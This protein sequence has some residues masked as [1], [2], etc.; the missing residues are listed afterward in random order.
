M[1]AEFK[2]GEKNVGDEYP[3]FIIAEATQN[4]NGD[5]NLAK[6]LIVSAKEI[7]CDCI[8]FQTFTTEEFCADKK[9]IFT[10]Y[11]QGKEVS[12]SE[13]EM[14][15]RYEFT[16]EEWKEI[17]EFCNKTGILFLTTVQDPVNLELM[18]GLGLQGIK[19]GSDDF[20]HLVNLKLFAK[21]G[22]PLIIS[23]GM[24]DLED[25]KRTIGA[26]L[27]I[28][29]RVAVLHCV[30]VYPCDADTLNLNQIQKLKNLYP[31]IVWG[32][33]D[34]TQGTLASVLAV[35][36]GAK[37]IEKHFTLDK[38]MAG[39]DHWFSM[40]VSDMARLVKEIRYAEAAFGNGEIILAP[41]EAKSRGTMRRRV[42]AKK[43]ITRGTVLNEDTVAFKRADKGC[44]L[45]DWD[46]IEGNKIN[47]DKKMN[48]GITLEDV[49]FEIG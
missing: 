29:K 24:S 13:Y 5:I 40:D 17:I 33:S 28:N 4:H 39:P 21:T 34:H 42:V 37:I 8:K 1:S 45:K 48:Q 10:Y 36:M 31:E 25:I 46:L 35:S 7:G 38:N 18:L 47:N 6:E 22:L 9:K 2:I 26:L 12:E 41:G 15:K 43:N 49:D 44:F 11:S 3:A 19:V 32:F 20:D 23:K 27:P 30:S 16:A 14:F